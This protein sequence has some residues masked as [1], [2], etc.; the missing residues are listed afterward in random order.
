M[1]T[2]TTY[3]YKLE[4]NQSQTAKFEHFSGVCRMVYNMGLEVKRD[5]YTLLRKNVSQAELQV[6]IKELR[7]GFSFVKEVHSQ[8]LQSS[9]DRLFLA[10]DNFFAG[11]AKYPKFRNK[12][13][14]NSFSYKQGISYSDT[15]IYLP[16]I[17]NVKYR[18]SRPIPMTAKIKGAT[19]KKEVKGWFVTVVFEY[20]R[21]PVP[22]PNKNL[23]VGIDLGV[24]DF[25]ILSTGETIAHPKTVAKYQKELAKKQRALA[26]KN[27][28]SKNRAK[29]RI[30]VVVVHAKIRNI[31]KDFLHKLSTRIVNE[32]QVIVLEDLNIKGMS[33]R[34]KPKTNKNGKHKRNN[35]SAKSGLNKAILD[36]G[37]G[38][39]GQMVNYKAKWQN[40]QVITADRWYA[41][42]K[43]CSNCHEKNTELKLSDR[44]WI[45]KK[46]GTLHDRDK[47]ASKNLEAVGHTVLARGNQHKAGDNIAPPLPDINSEARAICP[48]IPLL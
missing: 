26:R 2:I 20:E 3:R 29:A 25:A 41:S 13:L 32:N 18:N 8:V 38:E 44:T 36:S 45:C 42:S 24:K 9:M 43:E 46:C 31:R 23:V 27:K 30:K 35:Q 4:P 22:N 14:H 12:T 34:C 7:K 40:G 1:K 11:R 10:Y 47:N 39:F 21:V 19:V 37:W 33:K 28:G 15:H 6:Q 17:G 16:K 48:G 5:T